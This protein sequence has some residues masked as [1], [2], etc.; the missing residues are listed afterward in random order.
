VRHLAET[1][2]LR[3]DEVSWAATI[4][5]RRRP[6]F[7]PGIRRIEMHSFNL[8]E[9]A[10]EFPYPIWTPARYPALL[11][12]VEAADVVH[13]HDAVY[14]GSQLAGWYAHRRGKK[15]VVTQHVGRI[16]FPSLAYRGMQTAADRVFT[17]PLLRTADRVACVSDRVRNEF[18]GVRT[19]HP[20]E[21]VEN[22]VDRDVFSPGTEERIA[23][24]VRLGLDPSR[25]VFLFVGRSSPKKG[26]G[27]VREA[28]AALSGAQWVL[29][30]G[31]GGRGERGDLPNLRNVG[32]LP[33]ESLP[34][35]YRAADLLVLPS[36]GEGFPLVLQESMACGTPALVSE[37][38]R[39]GCPA[40]AE[41]LLD[42]GPRGRD[43]L[44]A[45]RKAMR[46]GFGGDVKRR[47]VAEF[48]RSRWSWETCADRYRELYGAPVAGDRGATSR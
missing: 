42:A 39:Q 21:V 18:S 9:K 43:F 47:R 13:V 14:F 2:A 31:E 22:G 29:I 26:L 6:P 27:L 17:R 46:D 24:R 3:G 40:A 44:A 7:R 45:C 11:R 1:L 41:W 25:P 32:R 16:P 38:T 28:A 8:V 30:G 36:V 23:L 37:E 5:P 34:D 12:A 10:T 48:A 20:A 35:W 15:L 33:Q 4:E 19:K